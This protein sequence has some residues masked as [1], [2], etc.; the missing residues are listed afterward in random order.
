MSRHF[1][2]KKDSAEIHK[3]LDEVG[4]A[5]GNSN[6]EVE[7]NKSQKYYYLNG[8]PLA[9]LQDGSVIP[10]L[11]TLGKYRPSRGSV[12][13]DDGAVP[14]LLNGANL[15]A[16]GIVRMDPDTVPGNLVFIQNL[17][18]IYFAVGIAT[19][20]AADTMQD[21]HGEAI[22]IIHYAGDKVYREFG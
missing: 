3:G 11:K 22:R 10:A 14:R 8:E 1:L 12:V 9:F 21:K 4:I 15:F 18:G 7:E 19:R 6:V 5:S 13:V 16:Q 2:S 17:Q 20:S